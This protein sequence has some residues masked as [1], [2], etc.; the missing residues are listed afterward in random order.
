[1]RAD[2]LAVELDDHL[3]AAGVGG[4]VQAAE[5]VAGL[6]LAVVHE[7]HALAG[8]AAQLRAGRALRRAARRGQAVPRPGL[9]A[10]RQELSDRIGHRSM[11]TSGYAPA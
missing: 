2:L 1:M 8:Q 3:V 6:I 9:L 4:P 10:F 7:L 11:S 5:I